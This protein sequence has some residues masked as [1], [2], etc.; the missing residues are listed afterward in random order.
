MF[1]FVH[2]KFILNFY[3]ICVCVENFGSASVE[4]LGHVVQGKFTHVFST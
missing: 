4:I 1:E 3:Y 2:W